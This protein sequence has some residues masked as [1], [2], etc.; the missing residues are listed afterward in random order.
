M[1]RMAKLEIHH[2]GGVGYVLAKLLN[3]RLSSFPNMDIY[4][5]NFLNQL[6]NLRNF[7]YL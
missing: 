6:S 1:S 5:Q 2:L 4:W 3:F 7:R